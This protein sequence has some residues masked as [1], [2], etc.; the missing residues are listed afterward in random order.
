MKRSPDI[1]AELR[2][3]IRAAGRRGVTC[4]RIA[5]AAGVTQGALSR[6][7]NAGAVPKLDNAAK[8]AAAC[9]LRL[10]LAPAGQ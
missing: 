2:A 1:V 8:I 4:Y 6:L 3:A 10:T 5:K 9:G 7:M